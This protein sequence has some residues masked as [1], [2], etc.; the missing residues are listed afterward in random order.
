M[1]H[2]MYLYMYKYMYK[3]MYLLFRGCGSA[4]NSTL[5][6]TFNQYAKHGGYTWLWLIVLQLIFSML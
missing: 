6:Y 4:S 3:Y 5:G 2:C 1:Q